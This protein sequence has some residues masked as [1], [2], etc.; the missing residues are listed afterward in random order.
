LPTTLPVLRDRWS[1]V[2]ASF[3]ITN[4]AAIE[5]WGPRSSVHPTCW[6]RSAWRGYLRTDLV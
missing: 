4:G 6:A 1:A 5:A 3:V 2:T